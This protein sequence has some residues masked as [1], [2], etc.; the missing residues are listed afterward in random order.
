MLTERKLEIILA[1]VYEYI[2]SGEPVGSRTLSKK[3]LTDHSAATVRNEMA[4]L[5]EEGFLTKPHSS[6]GRIPSP[7]AYRLYVDSILSRNRD[8]QPHMR[9]LVDQLDLQLED[10]DARLKEVSS[11]MSRLTQCLGV[12]AVR[13]S[14]VVKVKKMDIVS[15][16]ESTVLVVVIFDDGSVHHQIMTLPLVLTGDAVEA[17]ATL[18]NRA[19]QGLTLT[20]GLERLSFLARDL[21]KEGRLVLGALATALEP[22]ENTS[23]THYNAS[24]VEHLYVSAAQG[25]ITQPSDLMR[26]VEDPTTLEDL[27]SGV[28]KGLTVTIGD[29]NSQASL[30]D[31]AVVLASG[32]RSGRQAV[33][34]LV[35]P[36]RMNYGQSIAILDA[37][38]ASLMVEGKE[39]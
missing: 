13:S 12:A 5:E 7:R 38:M 33:L 21:P 17:L 19:F 11:F 25:Q 31:C 37:L 4:D 24:G 1:L 22:L 32:G 2:Q 3:Y 8:L 20:Q 39:I 36:L 27:M 30:K 23:Q 15:M 9:G 26:Y 18:A 16:A 10:L 28:E 14:R 35:G 34:G 29:E 6:A